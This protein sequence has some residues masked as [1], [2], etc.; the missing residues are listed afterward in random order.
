MN[1]YEGLYQVSNLGRVKSLDRTLQSQYNF[2]D[3]TMT[4]TI[5]KHGK[6]L[7]LHTSNNGYLQCTLSKQGYKPKQANVHKL[8]ADAFIPNPDNLPII[9][10]KDENKLNNQ[11]ENLEWCTQRYNIN[12]SCKLHPGRISE[13]NTNNPKRSKKVVCVETGKIYP[14]T[15][16]AFRQTGISYGNIGNACRKAKTKDSRGN[17]YTVHTAGGYHWEYL[18]ESEVETSL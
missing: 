11:A 17:Y 13:N 9:N 6:I 8:V 12:H 14:S 3:G 16:E 15:K 1:G 2:S 18:D 7:K 10:H 4:N 5:I